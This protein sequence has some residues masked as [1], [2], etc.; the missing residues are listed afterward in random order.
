MSLPPRILVIDADRP[1]LG[2]LEKALVGAGFTNVTGVTSGSFALTMLERDR[3]TLIVS[4]ARVPDV[5]G[6]ELCSIV[7]S[8]PSMAGVLFLL[9]AASGDDVPEDALDG[10]PDRMLVGEFTPETIVAEV[11]GLLSAAAVPRT[12]PGER[13]PGGLRGSLA[14]IDLPDLA[15]AIALGGKT[16]DLRLALGAASGRIVF[17]RGRVVHA[18]FGPLTGEAA[19]AALVATAQRGDHGSFAFEPCERVDPGVPRTIDRSV[20]QLLLGIAAAIDERHAGPAIARTN[21][22]TAGGAVTGSIEPRA[23]PPRD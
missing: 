13:A 11:A 12:A 8:D 23:R 1:T 14:V 7:R 2:A 16:G 9:L 3:P 10:G 15:Q 17:D 18:E 19:F 22:K 5:G 6:W 20:K 21:G 4:R